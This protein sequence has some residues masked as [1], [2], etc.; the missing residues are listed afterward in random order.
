MKAIVWKGKDNIVFEE[1]P[2][3]VPGE[4]EVLVSVRAAGV[5]ATDI[6]I[7]RGLLNFRNPPL[8]LGHEI[9]GDIE[10][11]GPGVDGWQ[12]GDR[13][14]VETSI[15]C[16]TCWFCR[17]G[18]KHLCNWGYDIGITHNGGWAEY[19]LAP[20]RNLYRLPEN[21]TYEEGGIAESYI[22]PAGAIGNVKISLEDTVL[23]LGAGPAGLS[24]VQLA[25]AAGAG[26]I[27]LVGTRAERLKIGR[28]FGADVILDAHAVKDTVWDRVMEETEGR[29]VDVSIEAVG[30]P[31]TILQSV[32]LVR[33]GGQVIFYGCPSGLVGLPITDIA[34]K[35]LTMY[36]TSGQPHF[37]ERALNLL[38]SGKNTLKPL[39]THSFTL[40]QAKDAVTW[41]EEKRDGCI[42][43]VLIP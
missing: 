3:P 18:M 7:I 31:E 41:M 6:H 2:T 14:V 8:I 35:E 11:I 39:V 32:Q 10:V 40:E 36:G 13:V 23:V 16:G 24:F 17:R 4:G 30:L 26:K 1:V 19:V 43:A 28:E 22:C 33:K 20:A 34:V 29:G 37:W 38:S 12:V 25:R 15:N 42:K 5:C 9:A 27:I 21:L